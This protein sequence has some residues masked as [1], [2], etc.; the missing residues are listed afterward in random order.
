MNAKPFRRDHTRIDL[1]A[2]RR[3]EALT[4]SISQLQRAATALKT[5]STNKADSLRDAVLEDARRRLESMQR[6]LRSL[7]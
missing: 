2:I 6:E 1:D 7:E 4:Y 3:R 5:A